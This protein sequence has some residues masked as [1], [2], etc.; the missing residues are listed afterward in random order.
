MWVYVPN[1]VTH[2]S[3]VAYA[4]YYGDGIE[5]DN[6]APLLPTFDNV[7]HIVYDDG[8]VEGT[9]PLIIDEWIELRLK[10]NFDDDWCECY[11]NNELL[12]EG[13]W[14]NMGSEWY[15]T[16]GYRN[17]AVLNFA[18]GDYTYFDD[19]VIEWESNGLTPNLDGV[20]S[21]NWVDVEPGSFVTDSFSLENIGESGS[22]LEW[23]VKEYPDFGT[24]YCEPSKGL[25]TSEDESITVEVRVKAPEDKNK[26]F[27]GNLKIE[28]IGNPDDEVII[29][30]TLATPKSKTF[31]ISN[32]WIQWTLHRFPFL[33]SLF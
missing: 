1:T 14:T 24:W 2:G 28:V 3:V 29:P 16:D 5:S 22:W 33:E 23:R 4:S 11:Y 30:V 15:N 32:P 25:L 31:D 26:E 21:F 10:V 6:R 18:Y 20:G 27:T 12:C 17:F 19:I 13:V 7:N 9:L 8:G